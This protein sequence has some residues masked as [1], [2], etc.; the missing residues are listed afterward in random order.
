MRELILDRME[1]EEVGANPLRLAEAIHRQVGSSSGP[2]PVHEVARALDIVEIRE[3]PLV[4]VEGALVT[5]PER[6]WGSILVNLR[7]SPQRRRFS[8]GHELGHFL[9]PW[10]QPTSPNGFWCSRSDMTA[11]DLR[12][13]DRYFRQEAEAN[14]FA[15]ELLTPRGRLRRYL[16]GETDL[17]NMLAIAKEFD[18][19]REAAARR[20]VS[21]HDDN[22][23]VVFSRNGKFMYAQ[24][25]KAFPSLCLSKGGTM[26]LLLKSSGDVL[27]DPEET[28]T[29]D[30]LSRPQGVELTAQTLFQQEGFATTLLRIT[31]A[32]EDPDELEDTFDRFSAFRGR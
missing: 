3:E 23:A 26:P 29:D 32:N 20:Y 24:R 16:T 18:I 17:H 11:A 7:S 2:V 4:N 9:N 31:T 28:P 10:H 8:V 14:S 27:S 1:V 19:S 13:S 15:I 22:L 12:S 5:T 25:S 30:W 21:L 6:G